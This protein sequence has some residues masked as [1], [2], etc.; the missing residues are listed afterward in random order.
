MS[1]YTFLDAASILL[2]EGLE[3]L[4]V[5]VALLALMSK[6]GQSAQKRWV[7]I[8][9]SAGLLAA[10]MLGLLVKLFF[11]Q[12]LTHTRQEVLEGIT[13]LV[14]A[15]LLFSVSLW[16]HRRAAVA[17]WQTFVQEQAQAALATGQVFSLAFLAF[18]AVFREGVETV[19]FYVGLA[20]SLSAKD[21]WLGIGLGSLVLVAVAILLLQVGLKLP[22]GVFFRGLSLLVFYLGFKFLGSGLHALQVADW[23]PITPLVGIP[24]LR[25]LGIY[26]TWQTLLPQLLL[27]GIAF[28]LWVRQWL[29]AD[30]AQRLSS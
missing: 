12:M 21:F 10:V 20:P 11:Q 7:W 27:L 30:S 2:R 5:L 13:G 14:A 22:L 3:A 19:L 26:P 9:G 6:S 16:L 28:A 8:G 4:L 15:G 1:D 25:W 29:R 18:V 24:K 23:L 17:S